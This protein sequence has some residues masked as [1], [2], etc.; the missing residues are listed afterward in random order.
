MTLD[1]AA[2]QTATVG[3]VA[4]QLQIP[5]RE[6]AIVFARVISGEAT[7]HGLISTNDATTRVPAVMANRNRESSTAPIVR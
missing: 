6:P 3:E 2:G 7:I 4:A 1:I 5:A